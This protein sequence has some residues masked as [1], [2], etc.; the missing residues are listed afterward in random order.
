MDLRCFISLELPA[1]VR[2]NISGTVERLN[3]AGAD[4]RWVRPENLHL[5]LKFLGD[6]PDALLPEIRGKLLEAASAFK[7]FSV[8][9][10]GAGAFPTARHPKV[11]WIGVKDADSLKGLQAAV[12]AA[13]SGLGFDPE[14]KRFVPHLTVGR[15]RSERGKDALSKGIVSLEGVSF[16]FVEVR[17][18]SLMKSELSPKGP[19]YSVLYDIPLG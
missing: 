13:M 18:V 5:T 10:R 12:E 3:A 6:T 14:E 2:D 4:V 19:K 8:E 17:S 7:P 9:L 15:V 11:V 16:G 1:G